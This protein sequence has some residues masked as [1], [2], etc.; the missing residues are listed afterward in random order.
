MGAVCNDEINEA[1]SN[2][3]TQIAEIQE[4]ECQKVGCSK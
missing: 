1:G 4:P 3:L 2:V